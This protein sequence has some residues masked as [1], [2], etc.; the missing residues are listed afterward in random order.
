MEMFGNCSHSTHNNTEFMRHSVHA[1]NMNH[2]ST[3]H[4][5]STHQHNRSISHS[6]TMRYVHSQVHSNCLSLDANPWWVFVFVLSSLSPLRRQVILESSGSLSPSMPLPQL[7]CENPDYL[8]PALPPKRQRVNS[9]TINS[10]NTPPSS[11]KMLLNESIEENAESSSPNQN[12]NNVHS[13]NSLASDTLS[14][15]SKPLTPVTPTTPSF[16]AAPSIISSKSANIPLVSHTMDE[17]MIKSPKVI[18][19]PTQISERN[20]HVADA[21]VRPPIYSNDNPNTNSRFLDENQYIQLYDGDGGS[22]DK[23]KSKNGIDIGGGD[24]VK[25]ESDGTGGNSNTSSITINSNSK[26][27]NNNNNSNTSDNNEHGDDSNVVVLRHPSASIHSQ[28]V[29]LIIGFLSSR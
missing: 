5:T 27:K 16:A 25:M 2:S 29:C 13:R 17:S 10:L 3:E 22:N 20:N 9:K 15:S 1:Y 19:G 28:K 24:K 21:D 14:N 4:I 26:T 18:K 11:P 6:Q 23:Y 12:N 8:P 7:L